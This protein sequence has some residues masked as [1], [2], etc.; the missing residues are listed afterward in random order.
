MQGCSEGWAWLGRGSLAVTS[1]V[2]S[3][4]PSGPRHPWLSVGCSSLW[5]RWCCEPDPA[6]PMALTLFLPFAHRGLRATAKI[7]YQAVLLEN[8]VRRSS[9]LS[10]W[11]GRGMAVSSQT[12]PTSG[13][14]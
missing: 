2:C 8:L 7:T 6:V 1:P 3:S 14:S 13:G 11:E 10:C 9:S 12:S 5:G 4:V